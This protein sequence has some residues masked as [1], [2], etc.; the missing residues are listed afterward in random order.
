MI[1][2]PAKREDRAIMLRAGFSV[3]EIEELFNRMFG[4]TILEVDWDET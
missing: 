3:T 1:L 4:N 2:N